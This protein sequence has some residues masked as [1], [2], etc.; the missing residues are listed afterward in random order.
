MRGCGF[1]CTQHS[2]PIARPARGAALALAM[3]TLGLAGCGSAPTV[4]SCLD[5]KGFLVQQHGMTLEGSSAG[6]VN[7]TLALYDT[8]G[9][10]RSAFVRLAATTAAL[11]GDGVVDFA[12]NPPALPGRA[13]GR[14]SHAAL[15]V[16]DRC[17]A[18]P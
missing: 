15:G 7:F 16:I 9:E 12:G 17:V 2:A 14:L 3:L 6:G 11:V 5:A 10:A 13:P 18:S 8:P 1:A 4:A